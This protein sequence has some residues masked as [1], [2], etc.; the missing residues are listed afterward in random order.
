MKNLTN[1][2]LEGYVTHDPVLKETKTGKSVAKFGLA[3]RYYPGAGEDPRVSFYDVE[4]WEKLAKM[5]SEKVK[6]G[7]RLI[8]FGYLR[9]D[10]WEGSDGKPRSKVIVVANSIRPLTSF[11]KDD[12][13]KNTEV[14]EETLAEA[15]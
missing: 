13:V 15:V 14:E 7:S 12:D 4:S 11:Y 2:T 9:Q 5:C 3:C 6:K 10:R 1:V 8:V